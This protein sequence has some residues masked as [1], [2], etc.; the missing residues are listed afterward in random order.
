MKGSAG[1]PPA[2]SGD[3]PDAPTK[4]RKI[5]Q[6][7]GEKSKNSHACR[8]RLL[9]ANFASCR[10]S[11]RILISEIGHVVLELLPRQGRIHR[12][13]LIKS[14]ADVLEFEE[15]AF[16]RIDEAIRRLEELKKVSADSNYVWRRTQ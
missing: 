16:K 3:S 13:D 6:S 14:T 4:Q 1:V 8:A 7:R 5:V 9:A 12:H 10:T 2:A 15:V 11:M